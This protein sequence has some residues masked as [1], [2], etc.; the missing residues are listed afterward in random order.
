MNHKFEELISS[1]LEKKVGIAENF[2]TEDILTLLQQHIL[3]LR[4]TNHLQNAAI[5]NKKTRTENQTIRNDQTYW[6]N[7]EHNHHTENL[8]MDLMDQLAQHLNTTCYAGIQQNEFHF[9][10]YGP[11]SYYKRHFDQFRNN[12]SRLFTFILYLNPNWQ[13]QDG[14]QLCIHSQGQQQLI[15]PINGRCVFFRS[16]ELEH[17]VL[18]THNTRISV[19]GWFRSS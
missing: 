3:A 1:Y 9:A 12:N 14:G 15:E 5:G 2:L 8:F 7:R 16:S 18:P 19:T 4:A 11:G 6:L 17:E 13:A 10:H